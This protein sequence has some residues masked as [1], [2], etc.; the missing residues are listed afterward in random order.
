[1]QTHFRNPA[2]PPVTAAQLHSVGVDRSDLYWSATFRCWRFCG[3]TAAGSP[4][5]TTGQILHELGLTPD[6]RA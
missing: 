3:A 2:V 4:Y 1:M 6:P 5:F